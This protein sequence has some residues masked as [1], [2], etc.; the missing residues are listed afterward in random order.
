MPPPPPM[1]VSPSVLALYPAAQNKTPTFFFPSKPRSVAADMRLTAV[2]DDL[3]F[4]KVGTSDESIHLKTG[5]IYQSVT[6]CHV[7]PDQV[8]LEEKGLQFVKRLK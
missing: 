7:E 4:F 2:M 5:N 6:V 3:A 8:V 1:A